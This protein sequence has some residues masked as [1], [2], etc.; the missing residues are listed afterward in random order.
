MLPCLEFNG[1]CARAASCKNN[2]EVPEADRLAGEIRQSAAGCGAGR[3]S[4]V[5]KIEGEP[6]PDSCQQTWLQS[7]TLALTI[8]VVAAPVFLARLLRI[9]PNRMKRKPQPKTAVRG[10]EY[11]ERTESDAMARA[12]RE[13]VNGMTEE[14]AEEHFKA[15][16]ALVY[17]GRPAQQ[18]PV[19]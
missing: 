10:H 9:R 4:A 3:E 18:A 14:Q 6:F 13:M 5:G 19:A 11:P 15:A 12:A 7:K 8:T 16:M 2:L 1:G 17:G